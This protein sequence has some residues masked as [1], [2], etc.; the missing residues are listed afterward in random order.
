MAKPASQVDN[1]M[2]N[3]PYYEKWQLEEEIPVSKT[4]F[5]QD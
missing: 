4:F 2:D 1:V 3:I 5:V